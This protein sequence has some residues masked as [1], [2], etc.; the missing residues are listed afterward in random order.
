VIV[1]IREK[2]RFAMDGGV[3]FKMVMGGKKGA[4][5]DKEKPLAWCVFF[6]FYH[7]KFY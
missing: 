4:G 7:E 6:F 1:F 2:W 5:T 3:M